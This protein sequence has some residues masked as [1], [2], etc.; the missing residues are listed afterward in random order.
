M[1]QDLML[2][3]IFQEDTEV[4]L[5]KFITDFSRNENFGAFVEKL[6]QTEKKL[7]QS[8]NITN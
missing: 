4:S 1:L 7:L 5:T 8:L 3:P 2:D 6:T